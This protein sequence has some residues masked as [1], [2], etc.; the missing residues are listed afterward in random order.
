V[1]DHA[2]GQIVGEQSYGKGTVQDWR[3]LS[4]DNGTVRI[5][6]ARWLTPDGH[7]VTDVGITPD[8]VVERTPEDVAAR[9]DPQLD[10]ALELLL[11]QPVPDTGA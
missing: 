1:Q 5:T 3:S 8:V 2:R 11:G 9:L 4:G 7:S 6:I 10:A